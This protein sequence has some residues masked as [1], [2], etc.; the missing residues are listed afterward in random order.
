MNNSYL[1]NDPIKTEDKR[2]KFNLFCPLQ[3][4]ARNLRGHLKFE[5]KCI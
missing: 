4:S 1:L 2:N 5:G 3:T